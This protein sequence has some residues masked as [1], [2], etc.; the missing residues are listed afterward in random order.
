MKQTYLILWVIVFMPFAF[1]NEP[2]K[3]AYTTAWNI[4][5]E[6]NREAEFDR[7]FYQKVDAVQD[8]LEA[9]SEHLTEEEQSRIWRP[10]ILINQLRFRPKKE[11]LE[12]FKNAKVVDGIVKTDIP[13]LDVLFKLWEVKEINK[14]SDDMFTIKLADNLD[15]RLLEGEVKKLNIAEWSDSLKGVSAGGYY[16]WGAVARTQ[17]LQMSTRRTLAIYV[18]STGWGGCNT[19]CHFVNRTYFE[20]SQVFDF[21]DAT[22]KYDE[23][24][25]VKFLNWSGDELKNRALYFKGDAAK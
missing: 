12:H 25:V 21:N 11:Y 5:F 20:V 15:P 6:E 3:N 16:G 23:K 13:E 9:L 18:I 22:W 2:E 1:S 10:K 17:V 8:E 19:G 7:E 24:F 4:V 14:N